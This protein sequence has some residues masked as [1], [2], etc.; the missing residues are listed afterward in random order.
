M[1]NS[2]ALT[3]EQKEII[4]PNQWT[5]AMIIAKAGSGKTTTIIKR[6]IN[7]AETLDVW[8]NIAIIS[9]TNKSAED[10]KERLKGKNVSNILAMTFHAFLIK[11]ILSFTPLFRGKSLPFNFRRQVHTEKEWISHIQENQEIPVSSSAQ[12]DYLM[13]Y[14]LH[15]LKEGNPYICKYLKTKFE[16]IYIDEAQDNNQL[17]YD[18]VNILI[19][20]SIQ[21]VMVGDEKQTIYQFR[22]ANSERFSGMSKHP[23]FKDH[24][25]T[26]KKNFRCHK[27]IDA[28]ANSYALPSGHNYDDNKNGIFIC[29][30]SNLEKVID[31]GKNKNEGLCFLFRGTRGPFN[32]N[33]EIINNYGLSL[34]T[35]PEI[36]SRS[37]SPRLLILLFQMY[38]GDFRQE[39]YFIE[40]IIPNVPRSTAHKLIENLKNNP[41]Q[42]NLAQLNNYARAY[43]ENDFNDIIDVLNCD[44][45]RQLY[46]FDTSKNFAMTI[47]TAKGLEFKNVILMA[48]D[49]DDL[50]ST[51]NRNLFYVACT[52][53]EKKL[54]FYYR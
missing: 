34:I 20:L 30:S 3:K 12:D 4:N 6:A 52:R 42:D 35:P 53:A 50:N 8:K 1:I 26:L 31:Y 18:I 21:V 16:A 13:S 14:A 7:Q 44:N 5:S 46:N 25:Y 43:D 39:I 33:Q 37:S 36:V 10:L 17:Q 38:F 49:F 19:E 2:H 32:H 47:H 24:I 29:S 51:E 45:A 48:S 15:I 54:F 27:L 40:N 41:T 23:K 22:G 11:H 9:F 28:C